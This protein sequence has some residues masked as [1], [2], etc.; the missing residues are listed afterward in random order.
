MLGSNTPSA[1]LVAHVEDIERRLETGSYL[2]CGHP[3]WSSLSWLIDRLPGRIRI[4]HL[5]RHPVPTAL[6]WLTHSAYLAPLLPHLGER[7]LLTPFDPGAAFPQYQTR[8]PA[9]QPFEKCL[10]YWAEVNAFGLRLAEFA[11]VPWFRLRYEDLFEGL[12]LADLLTFLDLPPRE[13][14][15]ET[16]SQVVDRHRFVAPCAPPALE[17][18]GS[19]EPVLSVAGALGYDMESPDPGSYLGRYMFAG[20]TRSGGRLTFWK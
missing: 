9:L 17:V 10:Y 1:A 4:V 5:T 6:S 8:W 19:H 20:E 2:E 14:L 16:R 13:E 7:V 18:L 12:A 3:C 11:R 15:L